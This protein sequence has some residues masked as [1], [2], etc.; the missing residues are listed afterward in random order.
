METSPY[1]LEAAAEAVRSGAVLIYPTETL[2]ALGCDARNRAAVARVSRLKGRPESKPLPM[3]VADL[4]GLRGLADG[5]LPPA[6]LRLGQ[7]FWP[8][9]LS[10]LVRTQADLPASVRDARGFSSVRVS[11]HPLARALCREACTAL[12]ATS[13]NMS[14]EPPAATPAELDPALIVRADLVLDQRPW[15]SGGRPST[16]VRILGDERLEILRQGAVPVSSL[17]AQGFVVSLA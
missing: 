5:A 2:Y 13:A 7:A 17:E 12:V 11:A 9:P 15:P 4:D 1:D 6:V 3:V 8:G 14:G 10:I 16:V